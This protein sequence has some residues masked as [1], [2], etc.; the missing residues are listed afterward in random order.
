MNINPINTAMTARRQAAPNFTGVYKAAAQ[1]ELDKMGKARALANEYQKFQDLIIQASKNDKYD[2]NI[3]GYR[4]DRH[5][6][7][8]VI[9]DKKGNVKHAF[10]GKDFAKAVETAD[11]MKEVD[12]KVDVKKILDL[13]I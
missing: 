1:Y 12:E 3:R 11:N 5:E 2:I 7:D 9:V 4:D 13:C 8:Y 6:A 10:N